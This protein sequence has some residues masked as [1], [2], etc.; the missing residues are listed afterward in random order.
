M[1]TGT[2]YKI[3]LFA[4]SLDTIND[5]FDELGIKPCMH[6]LEI[7]IFLLNRVI[8]KPTKIMNK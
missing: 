8:V 1:L 4:A 7:G 2:K 5:F 6:L 3:I